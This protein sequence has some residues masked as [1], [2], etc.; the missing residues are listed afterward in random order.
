M[1]RRSSWSIPGLACAG[2]VVLLLVSGCSHTR[3]FVRGPRSSPA[4]SP[5]A[6]DHRLLLIGDAGD[7]DP[8][9]EPTLD[10]L[11]ARVRLAPTRTTVVFLGDNVYET[12]MPDPSPIE[13][14]A[15]EKVLDEALLN[16]Y[17][18]RRAAERRVKMQVKTVRMRG[19]RAIFI[20][21]N[22]DWD[23]FGVG[24]WKRVLALQTYIRD[25]NASS[26]DGEVTL[27]PPD[28][29]PGPVIVDLGRRARLI[30]LDTQWWLEM[31]SKP[32]P[33][34]NP[35]GCREV[36]EAD[37]VASLQREV[38]AA[39][40]ANRRAIVVGHHPLASQGPHGGY[41]GPLIHLFP[42]LMAGTYVPFYVRWFPVPVLGT[43]AGW[44]RAHWSPN[45]QD[46][47]GPGNRHMR[48]A[49]EAA[50]ATASAHARPLVYAAG[51]DH[52]LQVFRRDRGPRWL[53]VSGLGSR[54][55]AMPVRHDGSSLFA[56]SDRANPG[57]MEIDFLSDG[58]ARLGVIE[59]SPAKPEGTEVYSHSL[60]STR[61]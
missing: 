40:A 5:A 9:G 3:P 57:F 51:H 36:T 54:S 53:L 24:G 58:E 45:A 38:E 1:P 44:W 30:A 11:E 26:S 48:E 29:C 60:T 33:D 34:N 12:G 37:V 39:A 14:T 8:A 32:A 49:L 22:H 23:Q 52:S 13:G 43:I 56:H 55:K 17:E 21:G 59:W 35:A 25:L 6:I 7:A 16:L 42:F 15:V 50:M 2:V 10:M 18:S 31:G 20:P 27:L 61:P 4:P 28:G 46:F 19:A 41:T 47:S